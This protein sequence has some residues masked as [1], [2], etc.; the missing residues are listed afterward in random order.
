MFDGVTFPAKFNADANGMSAGKKP[1]ES[2]AIAHSIPVR[3]LA[4]SSRGNGSERTQECA[5]ETVVLPKEK[6]VFNSCANAHVSN[7]QEAHNGGVDA[8]ARIKAPSAAPSK[9]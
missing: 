5:F 2:S 9:L 6:S 7:I 4:A 1:F 8:A 3:K